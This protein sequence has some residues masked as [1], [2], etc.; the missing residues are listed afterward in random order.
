MDFPFSSGVIKARRA[1]VEIEIQ[2]ENC[3]R[4]Q[5]NQPSVEQELKQMLNGK[6]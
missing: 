6:E 4:Q 5:D 1:V 3:L 2:T